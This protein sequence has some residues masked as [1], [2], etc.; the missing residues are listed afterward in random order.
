MAQ[1]ITKLTNIHEV[2]GMMP[3]LAQWVKDPVL[4]WLWWR[5]QVQ[6]GDD[7]AVTPS[8]GLAL[9]VWLWLGSGLAL[10]GSGLALKVLP[11]LFPFLFFFFFFFWLFRT[12]PLQMEFP[13]YGWHWSCSLQPTPLPQQ[14]RILATSTNL[15]RSSCQHQILNPLSEARDQTCVLK[16][17]S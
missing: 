12:I 6:L 8:S 17:T 3:G 13:G 4:L 7:V 2:V 9:K 11:T 14:H 15:H 1:R 16:D 10:V 5:S